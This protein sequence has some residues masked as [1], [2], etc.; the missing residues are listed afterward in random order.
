MEKLNLKHY[1]VSEDLVRKELSLILEFEEIRNSQVLSKFIE[2][3]V[4]KKLSGQE[5]EIKEYT[6]AV[7]GLGKPRDYNPQLDASVRIHAGRLRRLLTQYYRENGKNDAVLIDIPKGTYVPV[8]RSRE[9]GNVDGNGSE[10]T[11]SVIHP[12]EHSDSV[13]INEFF[14]LQRKP[15]LDVLPFH[16]LSSDNSKDYFVAGIGEQLSSE[17]ARFQ[18]ITVISYFTTAAYK[19][20]LK[21]LLELKQ[22]VHIDYVLTGS[23]RFT[24][25]TMKINVQLI[26]AENAE[27]IFTE[28]YTRHLTPENIF[29][30]EEEIIHHVSNIIADDNG[31][32]MNQAHSSHATKPQVSSVQD[33]IN[34][35]FDYTRDYSPEKFLT[36]LH[37]LETAIQTEPNNALALA[38]LAGLYEDQYIMDAI[39]DRALLDKAT[40]LAHAAAEINPFIQQAQKVLAWAFLLAGKKEKSFEAIERCINLNPKASSIVATMALAY[41]CQ[42]DFIRGFKWLL[43]S[44][45]LNPTSPSSTKLGFALFY[46]HSKDYTE[47]LR[48]LERMTPLET[49]FLK[50]LLLA[51][52]GK[53]NKKKNS[54][55]DNNILALKENARNIIDRLVFDEKLKSDIINGLQLAGLTIK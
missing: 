18:N 36:A 12:Q 51:L 45:H 2:F 1:N 50:L 7:K 17:M 37:A 54:D 35:Y 28:S 5:D 39:E 3:V 31:I 21:D 43:E 20:E 26:S 9:N 41:I 48:W 46:F 30:V 8:F 53:I 6:I 19:A 33:A 32:I 42:G 22:K 23:V 13:V 47:S 25:E 34:K 38:V 49:P 40:A 14:E 11:L 52:W 16:N 27:I 29:E 4:E 55:I 15:A 44:I 24:N 10:V